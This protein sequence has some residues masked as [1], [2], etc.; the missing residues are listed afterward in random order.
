MTTVNHTDSAPSARGP[1]AF[2]NFLAGALTT[3][4]NQAAAKTEFPGAATDPKFLRQIADLRP[5]RQARLSAYVGSVAGAA[6]AIIQ[7]EYSLDG[8]TSWKFLNGLLTTSGGPKVALDGSTSTAV[9]GAWAPLAD[10]AKAD[11]AL[12]RLVSTT[13]DGAI[14]PVIGNITLQLSA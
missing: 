7:V 12:L 2:I 9:V 11:G 6:G 13:G 3:D 4:T 5:F 8:G 1:V 14:D 10:L